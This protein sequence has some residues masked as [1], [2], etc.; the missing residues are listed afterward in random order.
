MV[1]NKRKKMIL[2]VFVGCSLCM[3]VVNLFTN[4][5]Y[6]VDQEVLEAEENPF[7]L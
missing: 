1:L 5:H 7:D 4:L 6:L 3:K 2:A